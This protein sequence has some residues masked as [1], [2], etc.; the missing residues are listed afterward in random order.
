MASNAP[1][2]NNFSFAV[3][4]QLFDHLWSSRLAM[5]LHWGH[6]SCSKGKKMKVGKKI[7]S[8]RNYLKLK[9]DFKDKI[10]ESGKC[11]KLKK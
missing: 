9:K 11:F 8:E 6:K 7:E 2:C 1:K 5:E 3:K 4:I 10:V